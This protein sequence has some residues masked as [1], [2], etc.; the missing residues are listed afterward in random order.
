MLLKEKKKDFNSCCLAVCHLP[1]NNLFVKQAYY[2]N[3]N[4]NDNHS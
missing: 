3:F 1:L 4:A 2:L